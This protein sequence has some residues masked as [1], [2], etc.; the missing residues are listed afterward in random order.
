MTE[1]KRLL[2]LTPMAEE[3]NTIQEIIADIGYT[4][5]QVEELIARGALCIAQTGMGALNMMNFLYN[6]SFLIDSSSVDIVLTGFA[7][8]LNTQLDVGAS[9]QV[10]CVTDFSFIEYQGA[11]DFEIVQTPSEFFSHV[12]SQSDDSLKLPHAPLPYTDLGEKTHTLIS[13][14]VLLQG[15]K[16]KDYL[17]KQGVDIVDMEAFSLASAL[18]HIRNRFSQNE[19]KTCI[20]VIKVITDSPQEKFHFEKIAEY[21]NQLRQCEMIRKLLRMKFA[22]IA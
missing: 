8:S 9:C 21:Q 7:G 11:G 19:K 17:Y 20:D 13:V 2:I 4:H 12:L 5:E 3:Y 22:E 15:V 10:S 14:P 6:S 18:H 16:T 1:K